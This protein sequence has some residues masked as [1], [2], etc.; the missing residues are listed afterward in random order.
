NKFIIAMLAFL[1]LAV[2]AEGNPY[3]F[4]FV[5]DKETGKAYKSLIAKRNLPL[6][7]QDG[8]TSTPANEITIRGSKYLALSGCMPHN[9]PAQAIAILYSPEKGDIH[10][11]FS[12]YDFTEDRQKLTWMNLD[13]I[14]SDDMRNILFKRLHGDVS[15]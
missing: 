1:P 2:S 14:D 13:P 6:W 7:V 10:G 5:Q 11:V 8:G 3:L 12:E 4:D 9:C 15:N